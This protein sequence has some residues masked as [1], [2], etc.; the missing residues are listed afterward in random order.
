[1]ADRH[2]AAWLKPLL[3]LLPIV[4]FVALW[5]LVT[6]VDLVDPTLLSPPTDVAPALWE[7]TSSGQLFSDLGS[8]LARAGIGFAIAAV[9]GV[10]V[11]LAI[12]WIP[13]LRAFVSPLAEVFRQLPPLALLP[14]FVLLLGLGMRSQVAMVI[15]AVVWPV[16]LSTVGGA[17]AVDARLIKAARSMGATGWRLYAKVAFPGALPSIVTGLRLGASYALLVLVSAEMIGASSGI[18]YRVMEA[19]NTFRIP[20]MYAYIVVLAVVGVAL[21]YALIVLVR[22]LFPWMPR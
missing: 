4:A 9:A 6:E 19:S 2:P 18:G 12:G 10:V 5:Q 21:N 13:T 17:A 3:W 1:M 8:S 20:T 22:R 16:L 11:G 7:I 14:A 15:W